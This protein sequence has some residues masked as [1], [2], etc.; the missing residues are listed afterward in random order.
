MLADLF[1]PL[2]PAAIL[3]LGA[4]ILPIVGPRLPADRRIRDFAA[5]ALVGLAVLSLLGVRLT[6]SVEPATGPAELLSGW[7]F[8]TAESAAGLMVQADRVSLP[9]I[10]VT[11]LVLLAV[12]LLQAGVEE[13][14]WLRV[15]GWLAMGG[16]AC[17]LFISAN[18]IT[19][20]YAIILFDVIAALYGFGRGRPN[21]GVARLFL[22]TVTVAAVLLAALFPASDRGALLLGLALWLRLGFYPFVESTAYNHWRR[23]EQ[24]IYSG[25][26]LVVGLY[27]VTAFVGHPLPSTIQWL[28]VIMMLL[29]G[30]L[31][32]LSRINDDPS[33]SPPVAVNRTT[34]LRWFV[35]TEAAFILL[36]GPLETGSAVAFVTGTMLSLA[37]LWLTL[38]SS[39]RQAGDIKQY[40]PYLPAVAATLTLVGLPF[41]L[42][43][44]ARLALYEA[45][46]RVDNIVIVSITILAEAFAFSGLVRYWLLLWAEDN[47]S[48]GLLNKVAAII[49]AVPF[50]IPLVALVILSSITGADLSPTNRFPPFGTVLVIIVIIGGAIGLGYFRPA[51]LNRLSIAAGPA[52]QLLQL[53]WLLYGGEL[54]LNQAGKAL[55]RV[56]VTLEGQHYL[57]W[58]IFVALVGAIILLLS[59]GS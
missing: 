46:L 45:L 43:W 5:S 42:G 44:F 18:S 14:S 38:P 4:L 50:L 28:A 8:S 19:T 20:A 55:L 17:L 21:L 41:S 33:H 31:A 53:R 9:F 12:M 3:L 1:S 37:V 27:L 11:L 29:S 30:L 24:L 39:E 25:L 2:A 51:I 16:S 52:S 32:W 54:A 34:L 40:W 13:K 6:D 22:G 7:N 47:R 35:L 48:F 10:W 56:R 26:S 36:V 57:G 59:N 23:D 15:S 58:A 49:L